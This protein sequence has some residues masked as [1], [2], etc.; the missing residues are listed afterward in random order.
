MEATAHLVLLEEAVILTASEAQTPCSPALVF[1]CAGAL[2]LLQGNRGFSIQIRA[3][4]LSC[5]EQFPFPVCI[6][7]P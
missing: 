1:S 5:F 3:K 6:T 7:H 2:V 4:S